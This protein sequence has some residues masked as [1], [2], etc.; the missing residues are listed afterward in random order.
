[1]V[2]KSFL[3][4]N[5][6][7]SSVYAF[8]GYLFHFLSA[9]KFFFSNITFMKPISSCEGQNFGLYRELYIPELEYLL[10]FFFLA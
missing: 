9:N 6:W 1:M 3:K 7:M 10:S 4:P 5:S 8:M 2:K